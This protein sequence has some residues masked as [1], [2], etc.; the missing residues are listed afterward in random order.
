ML[1][2]IIAPMTRGRDKHVTP[3]SARL[4]RLRAYLGHTDAR[5][6][7]SAMARWL[8]IST[9][10]WSNF[11]N[12][13]PLSHEMAVKLCRMVPGLTLDWLY[14]GKTEGLPVRLARDLE[15]QPV[16]LSRGGN[17]NTFSDG[18]S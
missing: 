6:G 18:S 1:G 10:R 7:Q 8:D 16:S 15:D 17:T 11:E 3:V 2:D 5:G 14:F 9:Q 13:K 4:R 12:N